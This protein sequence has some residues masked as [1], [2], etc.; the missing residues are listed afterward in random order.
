[1]MVSH[2]LPAYRVVGSK[3]FYASV[4]NPVEALRSVVGSEREYNSVDATGKLA[5]PLEV[6]KSK[7]VFVNFD[8]EA[9]SNARDSV[10][11]LHDSVIASVT[12]Q[13]GDNVFYM[14]TS[15]PLTAPVSKS[16]ERQRRSAAFNA[17]SAD[18]NIIRSGANFLLYY[19]TLAVDNGKE[20]TPIKLET[21][22]VVV[23]NN[24]ALSVKLQGAGSVVISFDV[25]LDGG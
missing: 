22:D 3:T 1:M 17:A 7:I 14:Y 2:V 12:S 25:T 8:D 9:Q 10:L 11:E 15:V 20:V 18:G 19:T 4:E 21:S 24:T 23:T 6:S 5:N 13:L 16:L